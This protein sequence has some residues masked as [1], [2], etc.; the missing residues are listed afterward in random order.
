MV[1][2]EVKT[3]HTG[4]TFEKGNIEIRLIEG[5]KCV[6]KE[7]FLKVGDIMVCCMLMGKT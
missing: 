1:R 5:V 7:V 6:I 2:K 4:H 3:E